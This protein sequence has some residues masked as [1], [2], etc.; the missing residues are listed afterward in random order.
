VLRP[1]DQLVV[2]PG[3]ELTLAVPCQ[4]LLILDADLPNDRLSVVAEAL[5][6]DPV[7]MDQPL[8]PVEQLAFH[9]FGELHE[10]LDKR[11]WL[12]G[13]YIVLPNVSDSGTGTFL[14]SGMQAKYLEMPCVGAY[15]DGL[16]TS[17]GS[18]NRAIV[19]G[20]DPNYGN[21]KVA[22]FQ[23]S[24]TRSRS[25]TKLG[26][27]DTWVKW[28]TPSAEA[29]RQACLAEE[30]RLS[31]TAPTLPTTYVSR[32]SVS[33]SQFLGP[34]E[35]ELNQQF[36]AVIGGRGT[37]KS[38]ILE[39][40]RWALCDQVSAALPE[41]DIADQSV[42]RE[43]LVRD[44]L[45]TVKDAIV[46]VHFVVNEL[47]HIVRRA[48]AAGQISL[49][50]G[51]QP[52]R[53]VSEADVR[54]V[55]PI[56]AYSQKQLSGVSVRVD[57]LTRFVTAPV[58]ARLTELEGDLATV[59]A[60]IRESYARLQRQRQ[61][62]GAVRRDELAVESLRE[63]AAKLR[64]GLT[65]VSPED[66][67]LLDERSDY[68]SARQ[69]VERLERAVSS[70]GEETTGLDEF[71]RRL[72]A[73]V[74]EP[75]L[76][77]LPREE[78]LTQMQ[79]ALKGVLTDAIQATE[80]IAGQ[81]DGLLAEGSDYAT[82]K[83]RWRGAAMDHDTRYGEARQR[84]TAHEQRLRE[85]ADVEERAR[86]LTESLAGTRDQL[87]DLG[88]PEDAYAQLRRKWLDLRASHTRVVSEQ[89]AELTRL[90]ED[91]IRASVRVGSAL[92]ELADALKAAVSGSNV[93][94]A[95]IDGLADAL[96]KK[97][98]PLDVW[99]SVLAELESLAAYDASDTVVSALPDTPVLLALGM[100]SPDVERIAA[101]LSPEAWL[102]LSLVQLA[103]KP[104]FA[105]QS[106]EDQYI[107]FENASAG[108]Q[109][110]ALL[111][112]LLNQQGPPLIID[113]PED[114]LDNE[115]VLSV[116]QQIWEA[117]PRRQLIFTSH[118]ANLVVNG[119]ADLVVCCE[120]RVAGDHSGGR[121]AHEGAIDVPAVRDAITRV[122]EGGE[123]A[124]KLRTAK[125]GF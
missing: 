103:D 98:D 49:K 47:P 106:K 23:T 117:K 93:R 74:T 113:Q 59:A 19:S 44:T 13:R 35:L 62:R 7:P 82:A 66:Q 87:R 4:A 109:A 75:I 90:S 118:N 17:L 57:E 34:V 3:I 64:Q 14:R 79:R 40:L 21:K 48:A 85:L 104:V 60:E 68:E 123:K 115:V 97:S 112:V 36:N 39:Y 70:A 86:S 108:Q 88:D 96:E 92:P 78:E 45:G 12:R 61:L 84:W 56:Q 42:R 105:Y 16:V 99:E 116:V 29:L 54:S 102:D 24:D 10:E 107:P 121:I 67:L 72:L 50:V 37:G 25:H 26:T 33:N 5:A 28:A 101:R 89:C 51:D 9:T 95:R 41:E 11:E 1:E 22:V 124:F 76:G 27:A 91:V 15:V 119:D 65:G 6:I 20:K 122:M 125:Y 38:T 46:E 77:P 80:N 120:Y 114:D 30:T 43:R 81:L 32:L 52:F 63:Q 83:A 100:P 58:Q 18:G 111:H 73:E 94:A 69:F 31:H 8:G 2:F 55:I 71:L 53:F 110:T